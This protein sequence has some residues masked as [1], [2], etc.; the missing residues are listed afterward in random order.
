MI[1]YQ[2]IKSEFQQNVDTGEIDRIILRKF[3]EVLHQT[4]G[5]SEVRAFWN[6]MNFMSSVIDDR[7]IPDNAGISIEYQLPQSGKRIDFIISGTNENDLPYV[8]IVE[9]K[10]WSKAELTEK[11]GIVKT[12]LG[13]GLHETSHPSY[14]VWSYAALL[15]DFSV[16]IQEEKI[17]LKPCAY[18]HN[19]EEDNVIKNDFYKEH[20]K[21]APAFLKRDKLKLR[22]FIK[23][24]VK[25]G[26]NGEIMYRI[27]K[28]EIRPSKHLAE[29]LVSMIKGNP[30]FTLIDEQKLVYES[31]LFLAQTARHKPKKQVMI[32]EGG[33]GTGKS[34]VAINLLVEITKRELL[35]QYVTKNAAPRA[36][37][38]SKLT[39]T[40]RKSQFDSMFQ[41]SGRYVDV[42]NNTFDCLI[43]DES[44][45]LNDKSGMYR[46]KGENQ[47]KEIIQA[48][49]CSVFFIDEDQRIHM[50]DIGTKEEIIKWAKKAGADIHE[51]E[52]PS[53]F[54]CN[55]SDG[56]L[57]F[58]DNALQIRDTA[59]IDLRGIDYDFRVMDDPNALF[60]LI[61]EKNGIDNKARLVAGYCW[62]WKSKKNKDAMDII[63]P[64]Y[65]FAKQWNLSVDGSLWIMQPNSIDQ[66]GCIH[67]CQGLEL[68]YVG[69]IIGDDLIVRDGVVRVDPA[70]RSSGDR[71]MHGYKKIK[72][73]DAG[74]EKIRSLIKNTYKT[75]MTRGLKGC[76]VYCTDKETLEYFKYFLI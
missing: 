58:I 7:D 48:A 57:A 45:R 4:T 39:G 5:Q 74:K 53:Q 11:D 52:L 76:Y 14:Q 49:A 18:L 54:R 1:V 63:F 15:E 70:K 3:Q 25:K 12:I 66:I 62:D 29:S 2:A 33:P 10:Q 34:V 38:Q 19:Y 43:V 32:V 72:D 27:D 71:S 36:V 75:L 50:L 21:K 31:A 55:G 67:T 24:F 56:Y 51:Y 17:I 13:G 69:V 9:L 68:S 44:H 20:L 26:D 65:D 60:D 42:P 23:Q 64:E 8:V 35:T 40:L 37:Y 47:I 41:G 61:K 30:E 16:P 73:T 6:S 28:G 46:N 59:N 22:E